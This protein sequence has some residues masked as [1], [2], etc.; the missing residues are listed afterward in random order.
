MSKGIQF[1]TLQTGKKQSQVI[2]SSSTLFLYNSQYLIAQ[3]FMHKNLHPHPSQ[4]LK[5]KTMIAGDR[6]IPRQQKCKPRLPGN[7]C[8][9]P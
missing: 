2:N 6:S 8:R 5:K 3:I 1:C 4:L 9:K 7:E